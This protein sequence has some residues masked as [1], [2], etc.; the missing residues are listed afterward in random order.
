MVYLKLVVQVIIFK[1]LGIT[2]FASKIA[3]QKKTVRLKFSPTLIVQFVIPGKDET[4]I[5]RQQPM[6]DQNDLVNEPKV[7]LMTCCIGIENSSKELFYNAYWSQ[8]L[9]N[10]FLLMMRIIIVL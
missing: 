9:K 4:F 10:D 2:Q 3:Q 7:Y 5:D 6:I 8:P 1:Y